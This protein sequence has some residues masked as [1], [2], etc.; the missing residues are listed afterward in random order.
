MTA[1]QRITKY[2]AQKTAR[3]TWDTRWQKLRQWYS[4]HRA[5]ITERSDPQNNAYRANIHDTK[6]IEVSNV[7]TQGHMSFITPLNDRWFTYEPNA[8]QKGGDDVDGWFNECSQIAFRQ[9]QASNFYVVANSVYQDRT[10]CGT[11]C[12]FVRKGRKRL[13]TFE[14]IEI[15]TY[16]FGEDEDGNADELTRSIMLSAP[17]AVKRFG[18]ENLGKKVM[19]AHRE[20][21]A[22][23][24]EG[25]KFEFLDIVEPRKDHDEDK[26]DKKNMAYASF[27]VCVEDEKI[28]DEGGYQE[29]P[30][31]V[32]RYERWGT[33]LWGFTPAFNALPNVLSVNWLKKLVKL[34]GEVAANPRLLALAGEKTNIDLMPGGTTFVSRQAASMNLPREWGTAGDFQA[35]EY[36][37]SQDHEQIER[38]FHTKLF[39]MFADLDKDMTATEIQARAQEKLLLFA[40]SFVQF[41]YDQAGMMGRMFNI[42]AREGIFPDAP[43]SLKDEAGQAVIDTPEISYQSKVALAIQQLSNDSLD[44]VLGRVLPLV[45][46]NQ[47][48]LDNFDFDQIIRDLARNEGMPEGWIVKLEKMLKEREAQMQA[49]QEQMQLQQA[50]QVAGA[51]GKIGGAQGAQQLAEA[52]G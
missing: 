2:E 7:L 51:L 25:K 41:S 31:V 20:F 52:V 47:S 42:L 28:I 34:I 23:K 22:G 27:I 32:S 8:T 44:R 50:E 6:S 26:E 17:D 38:F 15:G 33:E 49:Q 11:G 40:P 21:E 30:Y 12:M 3:S 1:K 9:L 5:N 39:R 13:L 19:E 14:Y 18:E 35:A 24:G 45:E 4:P 36:L 29:F 16:V 48:V 43:Q 10:D 46:F 37:I